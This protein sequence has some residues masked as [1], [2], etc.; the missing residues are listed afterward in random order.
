M[1]E[2]GVVA[3]TSKLEGVGC[4]VEVATLPGEWYG[5]PVGVLVEAV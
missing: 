3:Y 4:A 2:T 1:F 5:E